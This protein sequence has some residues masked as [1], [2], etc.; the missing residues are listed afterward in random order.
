VAGLG[1]YLLQQQGQQQMELTRGGWEG[2]AAEQAGQFQ[3]PQTLCVAFPTVVAPVL[4]LQLCL[5]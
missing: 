2:D 3:S 4:A 1:C 5:Y